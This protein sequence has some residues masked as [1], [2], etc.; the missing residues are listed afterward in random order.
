MEPQGSLH[1]SQVPANCPYPEPTPSNPTTPPSSWIF[2]LI[3]C[4]HLRQGIPM[5]S[6]FQISPPTPSAQ[7][8]PPHTRH[9]PTPSHFL[10][11]TTRTILVKNYRTFSSSLCNFLHSPITSF[12]SGPNTPLNTLFSNTLS[13]RPSLS[14]SDQVLHPYKTTGKIIFL[15]TLTFQFLYT[16]HKPEHKTFCTE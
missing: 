6:F 7:L 11:F 13:L 12:L 10:Y 8:S 2:I 14:V 4:T 1:Y 5:A 16:V 3:L 9:M 15:Y